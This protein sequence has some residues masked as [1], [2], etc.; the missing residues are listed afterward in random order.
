MACLVSRLD[1]GS[2]EQKP[3]SHPQL[4]CPPPPTTQLSPCGLCPKLT[5]F[6]KSKPCFFVEKPITT[7]FL[8]MNFCWALSIV[9]PIDAQFFFLRF[10]LPQQVPK[11][12]SFTPLMKI[13][14]VV[15]S[16]CFPQVF[17]KLSFCCCL[18][19]AFLWFLECFYLFLL[20]S[21][22]IMWGF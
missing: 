19:F 10:L 12:C 15:H 4:P 13:F 14:K 11:W 5:F 20:L 1:I 17:L 9:P 16:K 2:T 21:K 7:S 8:K 3:A 22:W 6:E 18:V